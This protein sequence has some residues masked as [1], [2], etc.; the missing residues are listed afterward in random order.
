MKATSYYVYLPSFFPLLR[1]PSTYLLT[2]YTYSAKK[3]PSAWE[4]E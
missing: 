2:T 4:L 1:P 3:G